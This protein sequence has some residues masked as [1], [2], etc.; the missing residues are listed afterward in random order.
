MKPKLLVF[1]FL[2][3]HFAFAQDSAMFRGNLQHTGVYAATGV[4]QFSRVKWKFQTKGRVF[5]SPAVANGKNSDVIASK[6]HPHEISA[7]SRTKSL[8]P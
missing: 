6:P 2:L 1:A 5:S 7:R 4:P 8:A 3:S